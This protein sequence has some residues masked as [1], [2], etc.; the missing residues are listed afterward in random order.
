MALL[1]FGKDGDRENQCWCLLGK[2]ATFRNGSVDLPSTNDDI[3]KTFWKW[4]LMLSLNYINFIKNFKKTFEITQNISSPW[5]I[6]PK[7]KISLHKRCLWCL[8]QISSLLVYIFFQGIIGGSPITRSH[9]SGATP[10]MIAGAVPWRKPTVISEPQILGFVYC[11]MVS[12][13]W[14]MIFGH[15][16]QNLYDSL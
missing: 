4:K 7:V 2:L 5:A 14:D 13:E 11:T 10:V 9:L 1:N 16:H 12:Q 3:T 6:L 15:L 8:W